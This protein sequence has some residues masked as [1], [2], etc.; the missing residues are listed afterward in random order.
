MGSAFLPALTAASR[1]KQIK[2][3]LLHRPA[4]DTSSYPEGIEKR[5]VDLEKGDI[6][7]IKEAVEGL[8]VVM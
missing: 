2:L 3:V 4:S 5:V 8:N 7:E 6:G 1:A